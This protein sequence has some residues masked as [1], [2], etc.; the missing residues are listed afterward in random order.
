MNFI[1][2]TLM[3]TNAEIEIKNRQEIRKQW[4]DSVINAEYSLQPLP[5]DASFRSYIRVQLAGKTLML[6][7]APPKLE[8][9]AP[10]VAIA[11]AMRQIGLPVPKVV[12]EDIEN[13]FLLLTDFG[14]LQYLQALNAEN[15]DVL[16]GEAVR[17]LHK[18]QGHTKLSG[19]D[20][21]VFDEK[22]YMYEL[23]HFVHW[24]LIR[25]KGL[26]LSADEQNM[27]KN[28]FKTL[29]QSAL[30]QPQVI[31]HRDYHSR[32][33]MSTKD[34]SLG[35][36]DFQDALWGAISYDLVSMV[37]DCYIDWPLERVE[38]WA[39]DFYN[40]ALDLGRLQMSWPD[41]LRAFDLMGMQRHLKATFIFARKYLRDSDERYLADIPRTLNY[42]RYVA[43]KYPE[44]KQFAEFL[45]NRVL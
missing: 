27:L 1:L 29:V 19:Y 39:R 42:V 41:F 45:D 33:L 20:L 32:N 16:Y 14:D 11:K 10:F 21:P 4:L 5:E 36:L 17:N 6:M 38:A 44:F 15:A 9:C 35:I 26:E 23:N 3:E 28:V 13:G 8:P 24:Y 40:Q 2:G 34:S 43:N 25:Y 12:A 30:G 22:E 37:R 31:A 7:D 18:L